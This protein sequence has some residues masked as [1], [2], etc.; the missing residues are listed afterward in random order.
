MKKNKKIIIS[1]SIIVILITIV[2]LAIFIN[3]SKNNIDQ[4]NLETTRIKEDNNGDSIII[5]DQE[6]FKTTRI[7]ENITGTMGKSIS[8]IKYTL[9]KN[10]EVFNEG[11]ATIN[12]NKWSI[13]NLQ[14][15]A[16]TN[17][18]TVK[19]INHDK[20]I[21]EKSI[22]IFYDVG[23]SY[24]YNK[25]NIIFYDGSD[26]TKGYINNIILIFFISGT[27][28]ER[29]LEIC[30]SING[31]VVGR[32]NDLNEYQVEIKP[33][34][35]D[36]L[37]ALCK[38]VGKIHDV[39]YASYDYYYA[40]PYR[41]VLN[42]N[43]NK[44]LSSI[45][46]LKANNIFVPN[47]PWR[48]ESESYVEKW[49][50]SNPSGRNW[51]LEAT[52]VPSAW[53]YNEKFSNIDIGIVDNGFKADHSD[54]KIDLIN[55]NDNKV[56]KHGTFVSGIIGADSNNKIGISGIVHNV[57]L[58]G[59][60]CGEEFN[61]DDVLAG[62]SATLREGCKVV[63]LSLGFKNAEK[64]ETELNEHT[65][66][67]INAIINLRQTFGDDFLL[68]QASG[69]AKQDAKRFGYLLNITPAKSEEQINTLQN[70]LEIEIDMN[71]ND[72]VSHIMVVASAQ[73]NGN[74]YELCEHSNYG[75]QITIAAPG[76]NIYSTTSTGANGSYGFDMGTSFATPIVTGIAG[77]VWSINSNL[78]SEEV[79]DILLSETKYNVRAYHKK[80]IRT[81]KMV[82]AKLS[83]E[84][85]FRRIDGTE[86]DT[87]ELTTKPTVSTRVPLSTTE[88][89]QN[90]THNHQTV[91]T[92][93]P[94][95]TTQ[96][97]QNTTLTS[98]STKSISLTSLKALRHS[99]YIYYDKW[100]SWQYSGDFKDGE[101]TSIKGI[102]MFTD[103]FNKTGTG[104]IEYGLN[105]DYKSL[106]VG[107]G[108]DKYWGSGEKYG[109]TTFNVYANG[110]KIFSETLTKCG[111]IKYVTISLP[112]N[113]KTLKLEVDQ[114]AT[115]E[116]AHAAFWGNP[117]L[118][119]RDLKSKNS[120]ST[121]NN[122]KNNS[123]IKYP[124]N[125]KYWVIFREGF[126]DSRIEMSTFETNL[127]LKNFHVIWD[128][129]LLLNNDTGMSE[130]KQ[131]CL[132]GNQWEEIGAYPILTDWATEIIASNVDIYGS[133]GK[134][135]KA[136]TKYENINLEM[137]K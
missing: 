44:D 95:S 56:A 41:S 108:I 37:R 29:K 45:F 61:G 18:L 40:N 51:W 46:T 68:I 112:L 85:A 136:K 25:D 1:V 11:S 125:Q 99:T 2:C 31:T 126:R 4:G 28:D 90:T 100:D 103:E 92:R 14:L 137:L 8:E 101:D 10:G 80:D 5:I 84:E 79:K 102:G 54:L 15:R 59:F 107:I 65:N 22:D 24:E 7:K 3:L 128:G 39:F 121:I 98:Q 129:N 48:L 81:Y 33:R 91:I 35:I 17:K 82:N 75:S 106:R 123:N 78:S 58:H 9:S 116:G 127:P 87:Q 27:T 52:Q 83:V 122:S 72:I 118:E 23:K 38:E 62:I 49:N 93:V 76:I 74:E 69:N 134:L 110:S 30:D 88:W 64:D 32:N 57:N 34:T 130:C 120:T 50:E 26:K 70:D 114:I 109:S 89:K 117:T 20:E 113:T 94:V 132:T 71:G 21:E 73:K 77:L 55:Q 105:E 47:D 119:L 16:E 96:W 135:V 6:S 63:N 60:S 67:W 115:P 12:S 36:E 133:N 124:S 66:A 97:K 86:L 104:W 13:D 43:T 53:K 131:F 19:A 42:N 111:K